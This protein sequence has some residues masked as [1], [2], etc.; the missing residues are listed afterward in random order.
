[1]VFCLNTLSRFA[2]NGGYRRRRVSQRC[3]IV[4]WEGGAAGMSCFFGD[5]GGRGEKGELGA[6]HVPAVSG[7]SIHA[8]GGTSQLS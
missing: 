1:M 8:W 4:R 7:V 2:V 5:L 3:P 6:S